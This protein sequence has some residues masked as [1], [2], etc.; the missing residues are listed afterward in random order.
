MK[1]YLVLL[2]LLP[3]L[4]G[5]AT[6]H[7]QLNFEEDSPS[8]FTTAPARLH[9]PVYEINVL[10]PAGSSLH[11]FDLQF[12]HSRPPVHS[13]SQLN[14]PWHDSFQVLDAAPSY[15]TPPAF[16][17]LGLK[18]WGDLYYASFAILPYD[19]QSSLWRQQAEL[20]LSY[21][22]DRYSRN[23]IP[24]TLLQNDFFINQTKIHD[25]Y[26][27]QTTRN[28]D[29]L[30]VGK[31][32]H[33]PYLSEWDAFRQS[34]G[35]IIEYADI[36]TILAENNGANDADKLRN[37]LK[38]Q[39]EASPFTY[40]LLVGDHDVVPVAYL[41]PEPNGYDLVPSDF[42][43]SDLSSDWDSN[44]NGK[45]GEYSSGVGEGDWLIDFTPEVFVGRLSTNSFMELGNIASRIV[46]FETDTTGYRNKALLPAAYFNYGGEPLPQFSQTDGGVMME[47]F[48]NTVLRDY[49]C[50]TLY[51]QAGY[52]PSLPSD[53]PLDYDILND[54]IRNHDYG[55]ISWAA[56]GSA[57]SSSR[58]VWMND[59]NGNNLPDPYEMQWFQMVDL[60]SFGS[61][62][63]SGG[64]VIFA[65]SCY[66]GYIDAS[67]ISLAE[68]ALTRKGVGIIAATRTGWYKPGWV[69]PGWGGISSYNY[70]FLEQYA[71]NGL[72]LGAAHA[73]TNLLHTRYYLFGDPLDSDG[74]IWPELQNVYTYLLFGDP[75]VGHTEMEYPAG[76]I[77]VYIPDGEA[78]YRLINTLSDVSQMNVVYSNRLIEDYDYL[79]NFFAVFA[80]IE[81][82][83]LPPWE[84]DALDSYLASGGKLYMEGGGVDW[85]IDHP[86]YQKFDVVSYA[87]IS[88]PV[89]FV[90]S[91]SN[92]WVNWA[93]HPT[94]RN[95]SN[96]SEGTERILWGGSVTGPGFNLAYLNNQNDYKT[97]AS[98]FF[99]REIVDDTP[100]SPA[101]SF[102][103]LITYLLTQ[104][105]VLVVTPNA[106]ETVPAV[107]PSLSA[108]PNP[109]R[110]QLTIQLENFAKGNHILAIYNLRGQKINSLILDDRNR[111]TQSWD[112]KDT[113]GRQCPPGIYILKSGNLHKK[114]T[115]IPKT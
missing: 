60:D 27:R 11:S 30:V 59:N 92:T 50:T 71:Q 13:Y 68:H 94:Y 103:E 93:S 35:F 17:Y 18:R 25:W 99:L 84:E 91:L 53:Y 115:L 64:S 89:E 109:S 81:D 19:V 95:I 51:E 78:D 23:L 16:Q 104:L 113:S 73:H 57:T 52:L 40:L 62:T 4:L 15:H 43:Y 32:I 86:L 21:T 65:A 70:H 82:Y 9:L 48:K 44:G 8:G 20:T 24:N 108:Y 55:I 107:I 112:G 6:L 77:L 114:I 66:N 61:I 26:Q 79:S 101:N 14:P 98:T 88:E 37:Y 102:V 76:E 45:Y 90:R 83:Q 105:E 97:I 58:K 3:A 31:S 54:Q 39:Y 69:N 47:L 29:F 96:Q 1:R 63:T 74:I 36:N 41:T 106:Q 67:L 80:I 10:L 46:A 38:S 12:T 22:Q 111:H 2:L 28:Y 75:A 85:N 7:Y 87:P 42:F 56:H 100:N 49:E 72:S 33:F 110:G 5:A 34:Q